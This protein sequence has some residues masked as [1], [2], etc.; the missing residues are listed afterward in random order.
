MRIWK[1]I[2]DKTSTDTTIIYNHANVSVVCWQAYRL[3]P[4]IIKAYA[5]L[6]PIRIFRHDSTKKVDYDTLPLTALPKKKGKEPSH[7]LEVLSPDEND[8]QPAGAAG[9]KAAA[10]AAAGRGSPSDGVDGGSEKKK[11]GEWGTSLIEVSNEHQWWLMNGLSQYADIHPLPVS[12][13][14][15][16]GG[17]GMFGS[18]FGR[19]GKK[20]KAAAQPLHSELGTMTSSSS[21]AG[22]STSSTI[23]PDRVLAQFKVM[24]TAAAAGMDEEDGISLSSSGAGGGG[25]GGASQD[26]SPDSPEVRLFT[27]SLTREE[28]NGESVRVVITDHVWISLC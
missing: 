24:V 11:S 12:P 10:V 8:N 9:M 13:G 16:G 23:S 27:D 19:R 20:G 7:T 21:T 1:F 25:G 15:G 22:S 18:L 14:G 17:G 5:T 3:E 26:L 4:L 2:F 6:S 28:K